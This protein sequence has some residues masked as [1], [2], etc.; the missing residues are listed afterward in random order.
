MTQP[1]RRCLVCPG[2]TNRATVSV[3]HR[4][5][6]SPV[7]PETSAD[8][9]LSPMVRAVFETVST[10]LLL[11]SPLRDEAGDVVDFVVDAGN[12]AAARVNGVRASALRGAR[13]RALLETDEQRSL[14]DAYVRIA[15]DGGDLRRRVSWSFDGR[16]WARFDISAS[17]IDGRVLVGFRDVIGNEEMRRALRRSNEALV[18]AER[19]LGE[20]ATAHRD[21]VAV[22]SHELRTPLA[23]LQGFAELLGHHGVALGTDRVT[24][25]LDAIVRNVHR[26]TRIIDALVSSSGL[27]A[28]DLAVRRYRV[29]V[30][31]LL[32]RAIEDVPP[33]LGRTTVV[34][35]RDLTILADGN[36]VEQV[37]V[38]LLSN[39]V[40]YGGDAIE[41]RAAADRG[42]VVISVSDDGDGVTEEFLPTLFE[43]FTQE[44]SSSRRTARGAGLGLSVAKGLVEA[45]D[46]TISYAARPGG[47]ACFDVRLPRV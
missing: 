6:T 40:K 4:P 7:T 15:T 30:E 37:V 19:E 12:V 13:I 29:Q 28:G 10:P 16:V 26:Q 44:G 11:L 20:R 42:D 32:H 9:V 46:G 18:A 47:G 33:A 21:F 35:D 5:T 3:T 39:A 31:P 14:F 41:V 23:M 36:L 2:G 8:D 1:H 27:V 22:A 43:M 38:A 25:A 17:A 34:V 45:M 24:S